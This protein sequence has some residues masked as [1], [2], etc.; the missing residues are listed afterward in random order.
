MD[1]S[2]FAIQLDL[3]GSG[4]LGALEDQLLWHGKAED[5]YIRAELYKLNVYGNSP[6]GVSPVSPCLNLLLPSRQRLVL[7]AAQGHTPRHGHARVAR[8]HLSHR[9]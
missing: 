6:Y 9:S 5:K 2:D 4:I 1:A 3:A 7:Q 8:D